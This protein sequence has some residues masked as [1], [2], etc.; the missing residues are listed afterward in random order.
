MVYIEL[1]QKGRGQICLRPQFVNNHRLLNCSSKPKHGYMK[2]ANIFGSPFVWP[3]KGVTTIGY[4]N[5][6]GIIPPFSILCLINKLK[7]FLIS[8]IHTIAKL[9]FIVSAFY[10]IYW[11]IIRFMTA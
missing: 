6:Q 8:V 11:Y 2:F 7:Q 3:G 5:N 9:L 10:M 4:N 1:S